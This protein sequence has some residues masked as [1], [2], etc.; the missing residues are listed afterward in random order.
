[1]RQK[2]AND[3]FILLFEVSIKKNLWVYPESAMIIIIA[4]ILF[5]NTLL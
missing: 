5:K 4:D 2:T 1:M 3:S